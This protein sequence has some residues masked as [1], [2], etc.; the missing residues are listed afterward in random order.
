MNNL[1]LPD[2]TRAMAGL[3]E[4]LSA[5]STQAPTNSRNFLT[6]QGNMSDLPEI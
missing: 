2:N 4:I 3:G 1:P 5:V 6:Q